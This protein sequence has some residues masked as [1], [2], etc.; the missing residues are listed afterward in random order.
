MAN[1][2]N[3]YMDERGYYVSI[4]STD[5]S[6]S[7]F[8]STTSN[9]NL[10]YV[11][12]KWEDN[13]LIETIEMNNI[14]QGI[15]IALAQTSN[16]TDTAREAINTVN[17]ALDNFRDL[18][19]DVEEELNTA[20]TNIE[21]SVDNK[22]NTQSTKVINAFTKLLGSY[23][24]IET[25]D[26]ELSQGKQ[27]VDARI[28]EL[29]NEVFGEGS[30]GS[31]SS[32]SLNARL[33]ALTTS[34][35]NMPQTIYNT[36]GAR[37]GQAYYK[38]NLWIEDYI[39][40]DTRITQ[41]YNVIFGSSSGGTSN[42]SLIDKIEKA[43][44]RSLNLEDEETT[45]EE[46]GAYS[47]SLS[48]QINQV[49]DTL[50]AQINQIKGTLGMDGGT[51][52]G[53][54]TLIQDVEMALNLLYGY[55]FIEEHEDPNDDESPVISRQLKRN[56]APNLNNLSI[57][58]GYPSLYNDFYRTTLTYTDVEG[59]SANATKTTEEGIIAILNSLGSDFGKVAASAKDAKSTIDTYKDVLP[60]INKAYSK[61]FQTVI[62]EDT[63]LVLSPINQEAQEEEPATTTEQIAE[64]K[65]TYVKLPKGGGGGAG[66]NYYTRIENIT[67][68]QNRNISIGDDYEYSFYWMAY[69]LIDNQSQQ[70]EIYGEM[71]VSIDG[72]I[73]LTRTIDSGKKELVNDEYQYD[74]S[75]LIRVN[76]GQYI[77]STGRKNI[78]ITIT[79]EGYSD[80]IL[81]GYV[82]AYAPTLTID[83]NTETVFSGNTI[84]FPYLAAVGSDEVKKTLY[85]EMDGQLVSQSNVTYLESSYSNA[86]IET[87]SVDGGHLLTIYFKYTLDENSA[88]LTSQKY[89]YGI[90]TNK[91]YSNI[92]YITTDLEPN[93]EL[94]QYDQLTANYMVYGSLSDTHTVTI[95]IFDD[96]NNLVTTPTILEVEN[97]TLPQIPWIYSFDT[98]GNFI[99]Q[100][101]VD[102]NEDTKK[103]YNITVNLNQQYQFV[104]QR[105]QNLVLNLVP[106]GRSN[107][108][109]NS[110]K[111]IW[112]N[113][114]P[115][116]EDR[117]STIYDSIS[118]EM[119][120]F[121]FS[122]RNQYDGWLKDENNKS[123]LRL[124]NTDEVKINNCP[125]L[126]QTNIN[127]GLTFEIE[128]KTSDVVNLNTI[129]FEQIDAGLNVEQ[130]QA[131][132]TNKWNTELEYRE[133]I[134]ELYPSILEE[135]ITENNSKPEAER[136]T[137]EEL[138]DEAMNTATM[139]V[140]G[141][142]NRPYEGWT[143][144][145]Y[146][147]ELNRVATEQSIILTPQSFTGNARAKTVLQYKEEELT[148]ISYVFNPDNSG[149]DTLLIYCYINGILSNIKRYDQVLNQSLNSFIRIGSLECTTDIY[150]IRLYNTALNSRE[151]VQN[152]IYGLSNSVEKINAYMRNQYRD[153]AITD[154]V[155]AAHSK[156]TPYMVIRASGPLEDPT[157]MPQAK[158]SKFATTVELR[159]VDPVNPENSFTSSETSI[160]VQGT[161]SQFYP[162]KNYKLKMKNFTQNNI[163]HKSKVKA[164]DENVS[165]E[166]YK[167][168]ENS[169]PVFNFCIKADY[170]SSEGVNNTGLARI[171]DD[172]VR[173]FYKSPP[174]RLDETNS[175]RQAVD[176]KPMVVFYEEGYINPET[177]Q[178]EYNTPY[179]LGKYNF[180]N[181]KGTHEVFGLETFQENWYYADED[182]EK[183]NPLLSSDPYIGDESWEGADNFYPLDI[184]MPLSIDGSRGYT[185]VNDLTVS[186]WKATFPARFPGI[187]EDFPAIA[188]H[189]NWYNA[190]KWVYNT[191]TIVWKQDP[192]TKQYYDAALDENDPDYYVGPEDGKTRE[193]VLEA[194]LK[195]FRDHFEDYFNLNAMAF[196]YCFTE[197]FL[198]VDNRA[199]NM[200]WT[201]YLTTANRDKDGVLAAGENQTYDKYF[202]LPYDFDTAMGIDNQGMFQFNYNL[203]SKDAFMPD[204][205]LIFNG[206]PSIFWMNFIQAFDDKIG[207][208]FR[209]LLDNSFENP[210]YPG[211][212]SKN[213]RFDY[214]TIEKRFEDHQSAWSE[215]IFNEDAIFKYIKARANYFMA[216]G[217]K[218]EQRQWWLYNRFRYFKSKYRAG[219]I[220]STDRI[221]MRGNAAGATIK[222]STVADCYITFQLG[223]DA[224]VEESLDTQR[225]LTE[226]GELELTL[227]QVSVTNAVIN[228]YPASAIKS[229][230]GLNELLL[231]TVDFTHAKKI[232]YLTIG[233]NT[234]INQSLTEVNISENPLLRH[235]DVRNCRGFNTP[236]RLQICSSLETLYLAGTSI[237]SV[238]LPDGGIL[239]TVQYPTTI[240]NITISNQPY[241]ENIIIGNYLP[242]DEIAA[243]QEGSPIPDQINSENYDNILTVFFNNVSDTKDITDIII[244]SA[245]LNNCTLNNLEFTMSG[246]EF[247]TL[248]N[249][250]LA[251][252]DINDEEHSI[253]GKVS[254]S[255]CVLHLTDDLPADL[256]MD[257]ITTQFDFKIYDKEGKE[258][259]NVTFFDFSTPPQVIKVV[260]VSEGKSATGPMSYF[261]EDYINNLNGI[262]PENISE[263]ISR[264]N[265]DR[266][267]LASATNKNV[268]ENVNS[269]LSVYPISATEYRVDFISKTSTGTITNYSY[270]LPNTDIENIPIVYP[271]EKDYYTYSFDGWTKDDTVENPVK[272]DSLEKSSE[273]INDIF[274][275]L[276]SRA[277]TNYTI[278]LYTTDINGNKSG[279]AIYHFTKNAIGNT[280]NTNVFLNDFS[281]YLPNANNKIF[282]AEDPTITEQDRING[283]DDS[284]RTYRYLCTQPY[285][286]N[287]YGVP[288]TGNMDILI[289]Y[290]HKDDVFNNYFSN[291]IYTWET[292]SNITTLPTYS[293]NQNSNLTYFKSQIT[294]IGD[295]S[296][297]NFFNN[298]NSTKRRIFIFDHG[299]NPVIIGKGCFSNAQNCLIIFIG[300][301]QVYV[302]GGSSYQNIPGSFNNLSN[303]TIIMLPKKN[304]TLNP[305]PIQANP[306]LQIGAHPNNNFTSFIDS[307]R[308]NKLYVPSA[309]WN[310]YPIVRN[311]PN[312][313]GVPYGLITDST[314][315][316]IYQIESYKNVVNL[317]LEEAKLDDYKLSV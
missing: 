35:T 311:D 17:A 242:A 125:L 34:V 167:L 144:E 304:S 246:A 258:Y 303:C 266:W 236:L 46:T 148:T 101:E 59:N 94:T 241:L 151:V 174:Q 218:K 27:T 84:N 99:L 310:N 259:F 252:R 156:N 6:Q 173:N 53:T 256:T 26:S 29:Y 124:R 31:T 314:K 155:F 292:D 64:K 215:T 73:V 171:Y 21:N 274:Y 152:W 93:I 245:N 308:Q 126:R 2:T 223:S 306:D 19:G 250:L 96:N 271:F 244:N 166:G 295:Y 71:R 18:A 138:K 216:Q 210:L 154:Q 212:T 68:P 217:S 299:I 220:S 129:F 234:R 286:S 50:T 199:K 54:S 10:R 113:L 42:G 74:S 39:D 11:P 169:I 260:S 4:D 264:R 157:A 16:I 224:N 293:F 22:L 204:G 108:E 270:A 249:K 309:T 253:F 91:S 45:D 140:V 313:P 177:G 296:F 277:A 208:T 100:F 67:R 263:H 23:Y 225:I 134:E 141:D 120:N 78:S 185:K 118:I 128:F 179:F 214:N 193:E 43:I 285:L 160:Q 197:F 103:V 8:T 32:N 255:N 77:R 265:F 297:M 153:A 231:Q 123:I 56:D 81:N 203:E 85:I 52:G 60:N 130:Q 65:S 280:S 276:Y 181:D 15:Q 176:G 70:E 127:T 237:T 312:Y 243:G 57:T 272:L 273:P 12:K 205:S 287:N 133:N 147:T 170:A 227:P 150:A 107:Q 121:L 159:Y 230:T 149:D 48:V 228:I 187:W 161:S 79:S 194:H 279:E 188:D 112:K 37:L 268:I 162:R 49:K 232:Q 298:Y 290:Y 317:L 238:T 47:N 278:S 5:P 254:V 38:N 110:T 119:N 288:V 251:V 282:M 88:P 105:P 83:L 200:F 235:L 289:K 102:N 72:S 192:N 51:A 131:I 198:M 95:S 66:S 41:L 115:E 300:S 316:G 86:S 106:D 98:P 175:V 284:E 262:T 301:G 28:T 55:S 139:Q 164:T 178:M 275:A 40:I 75:T 137:E 191:R 261:T 211:D 97:I 190:I 294:N 62:G 239:K 63:Y 69:Q 142:N 36:I 90:I 80:A 109:P 195:E 291:K 183:E 13:E 207:D 240:A 201:R 267:D 14:E 58:T 104:L 89:N 229:V 122:D 302:N 9:G 257:D 30:S 145:D 168:F 132:V 165:K 202:S 146:N 3:S 7:Y 206:H 76:L 92:P 196:F 315:S 158:G 136:K 20:Q 111:T 248:F 233:S 182:T 114:L 163:L 186:D 117:E 247:K 305:V 172:I 219:G 143:E 180:N 135:L 82:I 44:G 281:D 25:L 116:V 269:N 222:V 307:Y 61:A 1:E 221:Y 209:Q 87:P 213:F 283:K 33:Q 184:F 189:T 24:T 226:N